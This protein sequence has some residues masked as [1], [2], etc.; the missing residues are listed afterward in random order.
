MLGFPDGYCCPYMIGFGYPPT[1]HCDRWRSWTA[2]PSTR[3]CTG[4]L[5]AGPY[6]PLA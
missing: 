5:A 1:V 3:S 2:V 6:P 4:T